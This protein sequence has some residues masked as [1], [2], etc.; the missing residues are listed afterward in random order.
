MGTYMSYKQESGRIP[1]RSTKDDLDAYRYIRNLLNEPDNDKV[2]E[3][4]R[5]LLY[6]QNQLQAMVTTSKLLLSAIKSNAPLDDYTDQLDNI[7]YQLEGISV[8]QE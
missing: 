1:R 7:I 8:L 2:A 6:K 5:L 3:E 4:I